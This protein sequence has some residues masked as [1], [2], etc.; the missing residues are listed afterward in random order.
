MKTKTLPD[1]WDIREV[2][3]A[4]KALTMQAVILS[5][6]Y[7]SDGGLKMQFV[8]DVDR[9][10]QC[11]VNDFKNG[12][13]D[14]ETVFKTL[15]KEKQSLIEQGDLIL[16]KG[17]GFVAGAMQVTVGAGICYA[18]AA[19]FCFIGGPMMAHGTNNLYENG[20]YFWDGDED[21]V[22][23]VRQGYQNTAEWLGYSKSHGDITY[24]GADLALSAYGAF[25]K[26]TTV[27]NAS[28][29]YQ[30]ASKPN[31][32]PM[33]WTR[34]RKAKQFKLFR[35]SAEDYLRGYQTASKVSLGASAFSDGI[36]VDQLHKEL[37]K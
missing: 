7:I 31:L 14:K 10:E 25:A 13:K 35:Y 18:S 34:T 6:R 30:I 28:E 27:K 22:G 4:G 20:K 21:A 8:R 26:S 36:T 24:Y 32:N 17:V 3:K 12:N 11:L 37:Y 29:A 15:K 19:V 5:Q 23:V 1:S 16:K 33:P 2:E 9:F